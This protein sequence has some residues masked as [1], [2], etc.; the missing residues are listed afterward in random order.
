MYSA[1][2]VGNVM[3]YGPCCTYQFSV[4]IYDI[5]I[6]IVQETDW[7]GLVHL[8]KFYK[9]RRFDENIGLPK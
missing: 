8:V 3:V 5:Y 1:L 2:V 9:S 6:I 4:L 7:A